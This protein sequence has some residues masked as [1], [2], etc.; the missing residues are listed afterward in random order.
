MNTTSD[1]KN[2]LL[3]VLIAGCSLAFIISLGF[4]PYLL[5]PLVKSLPIFLLA[6]MVFLNIQDSRAGLITAGLVFSGI[7]DVILAIDANKLFVFGIGAFTLAHLFYISVFL[8][9]TRINKFSVSVI[10]ALIIFAIVI[11]RV[12]YPHLGSM[13]IPVFFYLGIILFMAASAALGENN[14]R[15]LVL[16]ATMFIISDSLIAIKRFISPFPYN[17]HWIMSTYYL[18]QFLI[19]YGTFLSFKKAD[20]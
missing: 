18:A 9:S 12:L 6:L 4:H 8:R 7:G 13:T 17:D 19:V 20:T 1:T 10:I 2:K 3:A 11:G 14:H 16:G 15:V 5:S